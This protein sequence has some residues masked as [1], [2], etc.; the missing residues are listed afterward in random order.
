MKLSKRTIVIIAA[1]ACSAAALVSVLLLWKPEPKGIIVGS[2]SLPDSLNPVLEQNTAGLNSNELLFDGL[3]NF[4]VDAA[5]GRLYPELALAESIEQDPLTKKTYRVSL[6]Q[7]FWHDGRA[8][9][10]EDVVY[11]FKAYAELSNRSPKRDYLLSFIEE[12][13]VLDD[14]RVEFEFT[15]P[16]PAFRVYP[17][18]SFKIIPSVFRGRQMSLNLRSGEN[19]RA[20]SVSPT[21]TGPF[22]LSG[23]EIGKWVNFSANPSYFKKRPGAANLVIK[24]VI[25]PVIRMNEL[26]M[27]RINLIL[28][29]SPL[30]RAAIERIPGVDINWF[31]PYSFYQVSINTKSPLFTNV[32][33][34][35]SLSLSLD[36]RSLVPSVTDRAEGVVLNAG[37]FPAD[38]FSANIPEYEMSP[39]SAPSARDLEKARKLAATGG[40]AGK[41]A[42]L[43]YPDS[44]GEFGAKMAQG[45]VAQLAE[46]GMSVEAKRT[47]DQVFKRLVFQERKYDL[48]LVH[49]EGFDNLYSSIGDWYRSDGPLNISGIGDSRLDE[50]FDDW[51][52]AV[53]T[54][55]WV[56]L[57]RNINQR[58]NEL[59]PAVYLCKI[60]KDVFSRGVSDLVIATDNP[61]LS[62]EDWSL[63][64]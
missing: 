31:Q 30:D 33:A 37:P 6:R 19:E 61:F 17:V 55:E 2:S 64:G 28:E 16:I 49:C 22:M 63:K 29:T 53:V 24:K 20:F 51:D 11:S 12:A 46:L 43:L 39:I 59:A 48:A 58:V 34:R 50:L 56:K 14:G 27:G 52:K 7:I 32:D 18:L 54:S 21:G 45:V 13:R 36:R 62:A 26:R 38:I 4:E 8:L 1:I 25:D 44:M 42:I 10:A 9:T 15:K 47:G 3:V 23:W 57:T 35:V 60:E 40:I 5:S 41:S